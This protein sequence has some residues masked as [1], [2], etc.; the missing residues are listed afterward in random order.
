MF[1]Y[2]LPIYQKPK[3]FHL[4]FSGLCRKADE[5][6]WDGNAMDLDISADKPAPGAFTVY[7][8]QTSSIR[9]FNNIA[10]LR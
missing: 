5:G 10:R 4:C 9:I 1:D 2:F 8:I 3:A 6:F 7:S